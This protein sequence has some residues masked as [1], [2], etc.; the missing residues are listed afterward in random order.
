MTMKKIQFWSLLLMLAFALPLTTSCGGDD[1]D[2]EEQVTN[3]KN[4][5]GSGS[6]SAKEAVHRV[7]ISF[8]GDTNNWAIHELNYSAVD[9]NG[10]LVEIRDL[11]KGG[12]Y[13]QYFLDFQP[14]GFRNY[15]LESKDGCYE[16]HGGIVIV[17]QNTSAKVLK[18]KFEFYANNK[19]EKTVEYET[20]PDYKRTTIAAHEYYVVSEPVKYD[21]YSI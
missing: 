21:N 5:S 4:G 15:S 8:S 1:D 18:V 11:A 2:D 16:L 20:N 12:G 19:K 6:A 13:T 3:D 10:S 7:D 9:K 17:R 14:S